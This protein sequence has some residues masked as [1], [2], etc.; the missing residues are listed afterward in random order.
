MVAKPKNNPIDAVIGA[1]T[2]SDTSGAGYQFCEF[3]DK[4]TR[5]S[6]ACEAYT[7]CLLD[8]LKNLAHHQRT[9]ADVSA[10]G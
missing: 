1:L 7:A 4:T 5:Q 10:A 9:L 6:L 8:S 3:S 2:L